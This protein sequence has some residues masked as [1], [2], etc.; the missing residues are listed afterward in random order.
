MH[1]TGHAS[2]IGKTLLFGAASA[3]LYV[4][5]YFYADALAA[6]CSQGGVSASVPI[7]IA[8]LFSYVHGQ[9]LAAARRD[10]PH[11]SGSGPDLPRGGRIRSVPA[12]SRARLTSDRGEDYG[13]VRA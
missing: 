7:G 11:G 4:L 12:H 9:P 2:T 8:L 5:L 1:T 6:F 3:T 13:P 10:G